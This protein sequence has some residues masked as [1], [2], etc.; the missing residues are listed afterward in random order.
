MWGSR[1]T[2]RQ[3]EQEVWSSLGI[4]STNSQSYP[5]TGVSIFDR[6]RTEV[7]RL[8]RSIPTAHA[9][10][11]CCQ[12]GNPP[13]YR[14]ACACYTKHNINDWYKRNTVPKESHTTI[15]VLGHHTEHVSIA[16][17]SA[18]QHG[19]HTCNTDAQSKS[20]SCSKDT[21]VISRSVYKRLS[22]S[23]RCAVARKSIHILCHRLSL[24]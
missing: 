18:S 13:I 6:A 12:W 3:I 17:V 7:Y 10:C 11:M 2:S 21:T 23:E 5:V 20:N 24:V 1:R 4:F 16:T 9:H 8:A 14:T 15:K 22:H 19:S